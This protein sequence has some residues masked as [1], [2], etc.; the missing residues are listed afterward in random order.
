M[1]SQSGVKRPVDVWV[2]EDGYIRKVSYDEHAGRRQA[3]KVTMELHDFGTP[4]PISRPAEQLDTY[5]L[6]TDRC[7]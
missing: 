6:T 2:D 3:A 4:V 5:D 7:G 1:I